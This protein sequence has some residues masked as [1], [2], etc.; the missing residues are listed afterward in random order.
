ME[1]HFHRS[2]PSVIIIPVR[3]EILSENSNSRRERVASSS[4]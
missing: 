2:V 4:S 1:Y 3:R